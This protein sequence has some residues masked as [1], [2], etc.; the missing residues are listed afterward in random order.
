MRHAAMP[1]IGMG[2]GF[3]VGFLA[4]WLM[5]E[6][7]FGFAY[8]PRVVFNVA[9]IAVCL[10]GSRVD[11]GRGFLL[12]A[13]ASTLTQAGWPFLLARVLAA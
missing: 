11:F 9:V 6:G 1:S 3:L 13:C 10:A 2:A 4:Q 5:A 8:W 7:M 12:A